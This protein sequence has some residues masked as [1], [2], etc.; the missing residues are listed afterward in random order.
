MMQRP[1]FSWKPAEMSESALARLWRYGSCSLYDAELV[2]VL[3]SPSCASACAAQQMARKI[4]NGPDGLAGLLRLEEKSFLSQGVVAPK[5]AAAVLAALELGRRMTRVRLPE[6]QPMT[7]LDLVASYLWLRYQQ[8]DQEVVGAL[9]LDVRHRLIETRELA[10]GTL[11]RTS[12]EPR[13]FLRPALENGAKS[14]VMF[15]THPSGH[16]APSA[17][18]LAFTRRLEKAGD[19][20]GIE[21]LDHLILGSSNRYVS[22]SARGTLHQEK[23]R[24]LPESQTTQTPA[25]QTGQEGNAA[26]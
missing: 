6:G 7:R 24:I 25:Y 13:M 1:L 17:Q 11:Q 8:R 14:I 10:Q 20:V 2:S 19:L 9:Y 22:L 21:L 3:V 4:L 15:H 26:C 5:A 12:V 16:P 18:D 23:Q